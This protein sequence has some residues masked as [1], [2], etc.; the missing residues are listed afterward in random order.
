MVFRNVVEMEFIG[1]KEIYQRT[2]LSTAPGG[3]GESKKQFISIHS[4][5]GKW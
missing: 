4:D 3:I 5:K 1:I 2:F